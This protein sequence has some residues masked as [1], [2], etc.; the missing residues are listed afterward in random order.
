MI[1]LNKTSQLKLENLAQTTFK[2]S[3]V[4]YRPPLSPK[5]PNNLPYFRYGTRGPGKPTAHVSAM[6][7]FLLP[8]RVILGLPC[9]AIRQRKAESLLT[10]AE[11]RAICLPWP[12]DQNLNWT[13]EWTCEIGYGC[14]KYWSFWPFKTTK[15]VR[16]NCLW[17]IAKYPVTARC[18]IHNT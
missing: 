12:W 2:L 16:G 13:E 9:K 11:I 17:N 7:C 5:G 15:E 18:R 3:P 8:R 4:I 10:L 14:R 6:F 1:I